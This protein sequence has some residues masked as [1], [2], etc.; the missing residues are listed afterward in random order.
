[1]AA[2]NPSK[3]SVRAL[4]RELFVF[5]PDGDEKMREVLKG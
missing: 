4:L 5:L 2:N 3:Q 1:M